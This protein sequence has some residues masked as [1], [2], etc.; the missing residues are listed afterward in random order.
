LKDLQK[1]DLLEPSVKAFGLKSNREATRKLD[2]N[3]MIQVFI[4]SLIFNVR[5][6][7]ID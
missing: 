6:N 4:R 5:P 3:E 1:L 2:S 7:W